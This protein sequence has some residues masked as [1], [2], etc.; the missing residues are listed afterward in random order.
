M[1]RQKPAGRLTHALRD[2][3]FAVGFAAFTAAAAAG[4]AGAI[5]DPEAGLLSAGRMASIGGL[6]GLVIAVLCRLF[7]ALIIRL[8]S[9]GAKRDSTAAAPVSGRLSQATGVEAARPSTAG[10][11]DLE[12]LTP[13]ALVRALPASAVRRLIVLT[14]GSSAGGEGA[15]TLARGLAAIQSSTILI[16]LTESAG[17][18]RSMGVGSTTPTLIDLVER[19]S[20]ATAVI[21]RDRCGDGDVVRG[22]SGGASEGTQSPGMAA[23]L[24]LFGDAY[25]CTLIT[26]D[27]ASVRRGRAGR[28][29]VAS[30][31]ETAILVEYGPGGER[32]AVATAAR[33]RRLGMGETLFLRR[34]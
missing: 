2:E 33:L 6:C 20:N 1:G 7:A 32:A 11:P 31:P 19:R 14:D 9:P 3:H 10:A 23:V 5:V 17:A 30:D 34:D 29:L 22:P 4:L 13:A 26:I 15:V 28:D 24:D 16:D 8:V 21:R 18:S 27:A 12:A 25:A